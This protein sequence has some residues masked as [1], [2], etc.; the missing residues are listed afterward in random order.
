MKFHTDQNE[1]VTKTRRGGSR[2]AIVEAAERLFLERGFGSV[3]MDDLA[4]VAGVARRTLYN[5]FAS[6]EEIFREML[7]RVSRQLETAFPPGIETQGDVEFVLRQIASAIL[8][9]HKQPG[10]LGFL[11]MVVADYRQFPWI[12]ESFAAI[13]VPQTERFVRYLAHVTAAGMLDCGN[14]DL[15]AHQFMGILNEFTLWPWMMGQNSLSFPTEELIEETV[16][17]FLNNYRC[18]RSDRRS[19]DA[20]A[21]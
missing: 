4:D 12:A 13:M 18:R 14:P 20:E 7:Q 11:R 5:Q 15:A 16:R 3:S 8:N 9:L 10:Y 19:N 17:M 6:K 2:E 21:G 1:T